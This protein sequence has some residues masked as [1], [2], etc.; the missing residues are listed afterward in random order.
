MLT[1]IYDHSDEIETLAAE[2]R[3]QHMTISTRHKNHDHGNDVDEEEREEAEKSVAK[4]SAQVPRLKSEVD[5]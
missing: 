1:L 3:E 2:A 5:M 4:S